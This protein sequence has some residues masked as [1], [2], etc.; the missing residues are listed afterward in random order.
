MTLICLLIIIMANSIQLKYVIK[1]GVSG[2]GGGAMVA[3]R[4]SVH[5]Y[6]HQAQFYGWQIF[7]CMS[8]VLLSSFIGIILI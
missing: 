6:H 3:S 4:A 2:S 8:S 1:N 7:L 5:S